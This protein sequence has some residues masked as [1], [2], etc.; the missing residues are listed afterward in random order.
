MPAFAGPKKKAQAH[1][2]SGTFS[3]RPVAKRK[4]Q[5]MADYQL[6]PDSDGDLLETWI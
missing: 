1:A 5:R 4:P 6:T 3:A 2:P